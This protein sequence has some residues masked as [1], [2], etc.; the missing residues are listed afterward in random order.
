MII[1]VVYNQREISFNGRDWSGNKS[2]LM[3]AVTNNLEAD[4]LKLRCINQ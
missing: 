3:L 4:T 2:T 1:R